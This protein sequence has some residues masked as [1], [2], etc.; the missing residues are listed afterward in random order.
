M[1]M[2]TTVTMIDDIVIGNDNVYRVMG[3]ELQRLSI[4]SCR[5]V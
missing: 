3:K 2:S 4:A 1:S 5:L